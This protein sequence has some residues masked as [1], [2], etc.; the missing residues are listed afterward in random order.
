LWR[1]A[2]R[3]LRGA[4]PQAFEAFQ[5]AMQA[6]EVVFWPPDKHQILWIFY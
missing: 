2:A 5:K 3:A 6:Q 4:R 1:A